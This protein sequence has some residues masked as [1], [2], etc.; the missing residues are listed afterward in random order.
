MK[1]FWK[2]IVICIFLFSCSERVEKEHH[3][4]HFNSDFKNYP[5]KPEDDDSLYSS[6]II[7]GNKTILEYYYLS[8][9][10]RIYDDNFWYKI[11]IV[12]P[13]TSAIL[14]QKKYSISSS[15]FNV[16]SQYGGAWEKPDNHINL[17][18]TLKFLH[19]SKDKIVLEITDSIKGYKTDRT[20]YNKPLAWGRHTF[21]VAK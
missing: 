21:K 8:D 7:S 10:P 2:P 17:E 3:L 1:D 11:Y 18:G 13:D 20:L 19:I 9:D 15:I 16:I 5:T 4:I 14:M 12:I 6:S